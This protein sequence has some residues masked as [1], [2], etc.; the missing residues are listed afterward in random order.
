[1]KR[2]AAWVDSLSWL[3][4]WVAPSSWTS[5]AFRKSWYRKSWMV[6]AIDLGTIN[7]G[8]A[9][10]LVYN[11]KS[12]IIRMDDLGVALFRKPSRGKQT[13]HQWVWDCLIFPAYR[14]RKKTSLRTLEPPGRRQWNT[15]AA[16]LRSRRT[17]F[18]EFGVTHS[19]QVKSCWGWALGVCFL[20]TGPAENEALNWTTKMM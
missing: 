13:S 10:C 7:W 12:Y 11:G 2:Q 19:C 5:G 20:R 8:M 9:K 16:I 1:M 3:C 15:M 18:E 17:S 4:R 6:P 14:S